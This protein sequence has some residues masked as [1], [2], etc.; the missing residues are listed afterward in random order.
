MRQCPSPFGSRIVGDAAGS[1]AFE[2]F[3]EL[4]A[5]GPADGQIIVHGR[6]RGPRGLAIVTNR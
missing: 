6:K 1:A 5:S 4:L 2:T 3:G